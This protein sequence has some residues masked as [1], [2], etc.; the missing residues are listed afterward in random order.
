MDPRICLFRLCHGPALSISNNIEE[1]L[2]LD[3]CS[4]DS[5]SS[6]KNLDELF[7]SNLFFDSHVSSICKTAFLNLKN[8][9]KLRPTLSMSNTDMLINVF[10]TSRLD[11]YNAFL[12]LIN[13]LQMVQNAKLESLLEPG[14]MSLSYRIIVLHVHSILKTLAI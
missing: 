9:S 13:K 6:V 14:S 8:R 12:G 4:V 7:E 2:T 1:C 5:S 3:G 11:Y 10:I